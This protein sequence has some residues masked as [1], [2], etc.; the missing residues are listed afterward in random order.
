MEYKEICK[1]IISEVINNE[2]EKSFLIEM[3]PPNI[4]YNLNDPFIITVNP[5]LHNTGEAFY[6]KLHDGKNY[7]EAKELCRISVLE[8]EYVSWHRTPGKTELTLTNKEVD[9]LVQKLA[10]RNKK[11]SSM[12][13]L[14]VIIDLIN[15]YNSNYDGYRE[16]SLDH[17]KPKDYYKLKK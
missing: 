5:P 6:F 7:D 4:D 11:V 9:W 17:I 2:R 16:I 10:K 12:T 13:N 15:Q 14:E 8:P 1:N 3:A